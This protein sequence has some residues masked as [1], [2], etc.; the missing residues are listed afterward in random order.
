[1]SVE[2]RSGGRWRVRWREAGRNRSREFERKRDAEAFDAEVRRRRQLGALATLD[3]GGESLDEFVAG[4]WAPNHAALLAP[5][6]QALYTH[7]YD[8]HIGPRLGATALRDLNAETIAS[9]QA[10]LLA[11]K[12]GP[13]TVRKSITL[14]GGI[15]QRAAEGGRIAHNPQR[16]VRKARVPR[17]DEIRP[18]PPAEIEAV[19]RALRNREGASERHW[20]GLDLGHRDAVLVS[21]LG[22]AGLRPQEARGLRWRDVRDQTLLVKAPKTGTTRT[23]RLLAPLRLDLAEWRMAQGRPARDAPVVPG[24]DGGEWT[25]TGYADW[26]GETWAAGL[27]R[28]KVARCRPYDLRHSFASLLLHEGRSVIYVARQL[29]HGAELTLRTYGHVI[30]ELEGAPSLDAEAAIRAARGE[31]VPNQYPNAAGGAVEAGA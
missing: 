20:D 16:V 26:R 2:R 17:A 23:V 9:W 15:L 10:D 22:Y 8:R 13:P 27:E 3:A 21:L 7:L 29:G 6:T 19:R 25:A 30:D 4:T 11:A 18:L 14:L 24:A 1:M 31:L 12:V 5:A 28:A